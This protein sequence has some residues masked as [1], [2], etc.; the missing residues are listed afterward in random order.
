M[1]G[2]PQRARGLLAC[3]TLALA[4][5]AGAHAH[6]GLNRLLAN[7]TTIP[8]HL[9]ENPFAGGAGALGGGKAAGR[10]LR[11]LLEEPA[12]VLEEWKKIGRYTEIAN[13][14]MPGAPAAGWV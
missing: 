3:A 7:T 14:D 1:V 11:A 10:P 9:L 6:P 12:A 2:V 8:L 4:C 5:A 13:P